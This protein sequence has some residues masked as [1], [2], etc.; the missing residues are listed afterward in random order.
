MYCWNTL[1]LYINNDAWICKIFLSTLGDLAMRWFSK[2]PARSI[3]CFESLADIFTNTYSVYRYV[4]KHHEAIFNMAAQSKDESL[5]AYL[6]RFCLE[7]AKVE[8]PDDRLA[9]MV[10][11]QTFYVHSPLSQKLNKR[12]YDYATLAKCFDVV[13]ELTN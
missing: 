8:R 3:G 5:K 12:K 2:L 10:F 11:K 4:C 9:T 13:N 7:L 6:K 1:P